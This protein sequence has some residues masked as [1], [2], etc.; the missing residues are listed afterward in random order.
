MLTTVSPSPGLA[1]AGSCFRRMAVYSLPATENGPSRCSDAADGAAGAVALAGRVNGC[2][3]EAV[4]AG[5]RKAV[6]FALAFW[7]EFGV[8]V[9][10]AACGLSL[11]P[12][13]KNHTLSTHRQ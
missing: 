10:L 9:P 4:E 6:G 12:T 5:M 3:E 2:A 8:F 11:R 7:G 13:Q 1:P